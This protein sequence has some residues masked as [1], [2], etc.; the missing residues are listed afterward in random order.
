MRSV[1]S[2]CAAAGAEGLRADVVTSRAAA[3]LAGWEGREE[4]TLAEVRRVLPMALAHRGR[5]SPLEDH[6]LDRPAL[7][8]ALRGLEGAHEEQGGPEDRVAPPAPPSPVVALGAAR[9]PDA[10]PASLGR[11][12][13]AKGSR[14]RL[15]ADRPEGVGEKAGG[16]A[17]GATARAAAA[18][19]RVDPEA[20]ALVAEDRLL[21][22]SVEIARLHRSSWNDRAGRVKHRPLD[23]GAGNLCLRKHE[24]CHQE[25][26]KDK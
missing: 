21:Y 10:R 17:L 11:R 18:R 23:S 6:G 19:R 26:G 1:A 14:G 25:N 16:L 4:A 9:G 20:P 22:L 15:V 8:E 5:R 2:V 13:T 3:A 7:E 24:A 12:T